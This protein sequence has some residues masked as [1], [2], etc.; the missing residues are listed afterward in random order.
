MSLVI[1][2]KSFTYVAELSV[3]CDVLSLYPKF[4]RSNHLRSGSRNMI[5]RYGLSMSPCMVPLCIWTG[6]V[7]PKC[8]L[9][10]IVDEL[11]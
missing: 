4:P 9:K 3:Y 10:N 8:D 2:A 6:L 1:M 11:E 5:K 7:L